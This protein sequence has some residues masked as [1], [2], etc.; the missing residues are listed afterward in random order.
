MKIRALIAAALMLPGLASAQQSP[1]P[2]SVT[3]QVARCEEV[4]KMIATI[5]RARDQG[6]PMSGVLQSLQQA[7]GHAPDMNDPADRAV[8]QYVAALYTEH[9][10][11]EASQQRYTN[12]CIQGVTKG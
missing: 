10:T 1:A 2:P 12:G 11:P 7:S 4:G 3:A 5:V 9:D 8:V 6:V